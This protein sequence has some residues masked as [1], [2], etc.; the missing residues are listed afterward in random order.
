MLCDKQDLILII[1]Q[2]FCWMLVKIFLV[3]ESWSFIFIG[4]SQS[5]GY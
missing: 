2:N 3:K 1:N 4:G 5:D